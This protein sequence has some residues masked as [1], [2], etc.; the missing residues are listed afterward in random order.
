MHPQHWPK[1]LD[2]A[3]KKVVVIGSGATAITLIP[4]MTRG[5]KAAKHVTMLQRSPTYMFARPSRMTIVSQ[6][7]AAWFGHSVARWYFVMFSMFQYSFCKFFP[8]AAKQGM[9]DLAEHQVG[10]KVFRKEDL[11]QGYVG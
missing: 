6:K 7:I 1:D 4:A 11:T 10:E 8:K 9:I 2:Y 5:P 3:N